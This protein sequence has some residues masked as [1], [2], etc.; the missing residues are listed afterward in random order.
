M[1]FHD[2]LKLNA[3]SWQKSYG[4]GTTMHGD[5][6]II[7]VQDTINIISDLS[8][9]FMQACNWFRQTVPGNPKKKLDPILTQEPGHIER[10][11]RKRMQ[12]ALKSDTAPVVHVVAL[13]RTAKTEVDPAVDGEIK[14][15]GMGRDY[16]C[17]WIVK[18][19]NRLQACGPGRRDRKLIWI[20]AHPA[21]PDDKPLK[22][23]TTVYAVVR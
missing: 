15:S 16:Q 3:A 14:P 5:P 12:K 8:L 6:M 23:K 10:H 11:H 21:G 20:E 7:S 22:T 9:F 17:R 13:R 4:P 18:G 1:S 2:M 19:H